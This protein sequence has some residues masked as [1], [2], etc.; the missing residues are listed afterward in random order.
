MGSSKSKTIFESAVI[1]EFLG[2]LQAD[3]TIAAIRDKQ[4]G[5][6]RIISR[7]GSHTFTL[8]MQRVLPRYEELIRKVAEEYQLD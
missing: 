3:G 7:I 8:N 1:N 4:F 5:H 2:K 6:S